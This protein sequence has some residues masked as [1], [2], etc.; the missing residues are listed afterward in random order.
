MMIAVLLRLC[1]WNIIFTNCC[2]NIFAHMLVSHCSYVVHC[3]TRYN[4]FLYSKFEVPFIVTSCHLQY[5]TLFF[6]L[7]V[8]WAKQLGMFNGWPL[9]IRII[10]VIYSVVVHNQW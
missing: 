2:R 8:V 3:F 1:I 5:I 4:V 10:V 7:W 9:L 6:A